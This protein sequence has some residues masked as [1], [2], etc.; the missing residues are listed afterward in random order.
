MN[1]YS[2]VNRKIMK[3]VSLIYFLYFIQTIIRT[4]IGLASNSY[5]VLVYC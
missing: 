3:N 5:K 4:K 2:K 1:N